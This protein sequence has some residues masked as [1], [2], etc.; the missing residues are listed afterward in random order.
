MIVGGVI[1]LIVALICFFIARSQAS[2][3]Q[4]MNAAD[5]YTAQ[6]LTDFHK[7]VTSTLGADALAQ[8]CEVEGVI[9]CD[10]PLTAPLSGMACV[11][12]T[13]TITREYEEDVTTTDA[14]GKSQT[15]TERRSETLENEDRRVNFWVRDATG[16][17][18]VNPE[19][20][21]LDLV[22]TANRYE[23]APAPGFGR[24][25]TLG[26]RSVEHALALGTKVYV[27]G[28]AVDLQ[29]QP[30]IARG[31]RDSKAKF[32]ISR[33]SEHELAQSAASWSRNLYY[34]AAGSGVLGLVLLVVG[35]VRR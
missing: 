29:G 6:L 23:T 34:A 33:R 12:Y 1:L 15:T 14:E 30:A 5:T 13:R 19:A 3:L 35:L 16:R 2:Q 24:T 20:A 11:A 28:C 4:A 7:Q 21:E 9:E 8:P 31:P 18:L 26:Q 25:R 22:E 10:A 27:L 32:L 17:A